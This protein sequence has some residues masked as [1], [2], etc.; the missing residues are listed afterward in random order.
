MAYA[1]HIGIDAVCPVNWE[2]PLNEGLLSWWLPPWGW[3]GGKV[4]HDIAKGNH[5]SLSNFSTPAFPSGSGWTSGKGVFP[6]IRCSHTTG[7]LGSTITV[8]AFTAAFSCFYAFEAACFAI[9]HST[10]TQKIGFNSSTQA[11]VRLNNGG[12]GQTPTIKSPLNRWVHYLVTTDGV[13]GQANLW[14]DGDKYALTAVSASSSWNRLLID[15]GSFPFAGSVSAIRFNSRMFS[16]GECLAYQIEAS[17]D[18]PNLLRRTG[19]RSIFVPDA[20]GGGFS[21]WWATRRPRTIG[22]GVI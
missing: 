1:N 14:I 13:G 6:A 20:A 19:T 12:T 11:F 2:H 5:A 8:T 21:P 22:M 15:Q 17:R 4:W 10:Q 18:F 9:G 3:V 16:D 7:T